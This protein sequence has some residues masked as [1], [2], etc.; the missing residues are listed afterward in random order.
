MNTHTYTSLPSHAYYTSYNTTTQPTTLSQWTSASSNT[1]YRF[2]APL[3]GTFAAV[4][5]PA[6]LPVFSIPEEKKTAVNTHRHTHKNIQHFSSSLWDSMD[7]S[8]EHR[9]S[10][11][12]SPWQIGQHI[13]AC[14]LCRKEKRLPCTH[15]STSLPPHAYFTLYTAYGK[16]RK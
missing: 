7:N 3:L 14:Y 2:K 6:M 9:L 15:T 4:I 8:G 12:L 1:G 5:V 16:F 11:L 10:S 13:T